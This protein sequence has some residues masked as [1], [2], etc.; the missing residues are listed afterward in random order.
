MV[1]ERYD[2]SENEDYSDAFDDKAVRHGRSQK[3]ELTKKLSSKSWVCF[4]IV[5]RMHIS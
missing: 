4:G 3:L 2:E 5:F 1:I